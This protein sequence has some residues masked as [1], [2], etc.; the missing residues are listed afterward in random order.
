MAIYKINAELH[1]VVSIG[2]YDEDKKCMYQ[3]VG[4]TTNGSKKFVSFVKIKY[5]PVL[6]MSENRISYDMFKAMKNKIDVKYL[7]AYPKGKNI[8]EEM[9]EGDNYTIIPSSEIEGI[10]NTIMDFRRN[11]SLE[12]YISMGKS[13]TG[14][15]KNIFMS[16]RDYTLRELMEDKSHMNKIFL[17]KKEFLNFQN[18]QL[19]E[20][21]VIKVDGEA[22]ET[23]TSGIMPVLEHVYEG[24]LEGSKWL[25]YYRHTFFKEGKFSE[26]LFLL[27]DVDDENIVYSLSPVGEED[28]LEVLQNYLS[29]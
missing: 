28:S 6:V 1:N 10:E 18:S 14:V 27:N 8:F 13:L 17:T 29:S 19:V 24:R 11:G 7:I 26:R 16:V 3:A 23:H 4:E 22:K 9:S 5:E 12:K 21:M 15:R 2:D 25:T 20:N